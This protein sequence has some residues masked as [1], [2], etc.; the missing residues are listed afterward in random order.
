MQ[1]NGFALKLLILIVYHQECQTTQDRNFGYAIGPNTIYKSNKD[2]VITLETDVQPLAEVEVLH[3]KFRTKLK[4]NSI[5]ALGRTNEHSFK[6]ELMDGR[7]VFHFSDS[8]DLSISSYSLP[9]KQLDDGEWHRLIVQRT[10]SKFEVSIDGSKY[11]EI[12]FNKPLMQN[13][14][15][16]SRIILGFNNEL[17]RMIRFD[18]E[19]AEVITSVNN[20]PL[21]MKE[22]PITLNEMTDV[23]FPEQANEIDKVIIRVDMA[24]VAS[25]ALRPEERPLTLF[26]NEEKHVVSFGVSFRSATDGIIASM[27]GLR[28]KHFVGI[29]IVKQA[30]FLTVRSDQT[31]LQRQELGTV[32]PNT[33]HTLHL[34]NDRQ[35]DIAVISAWLTSNRQSPVSFKVSDPFLVDRISFGGRAND[36]PDLF[37]N[38]RPI[39]GC[40]SKPYL[41]LFTLDLKSLLPAGLTGCAVDGDITMLSDHQWRY[42]DHTEAITFH[43]GDRPLPFTYAENDGRN[44]SSLQLEFATV[45]PSGIIASLHDNK[46]NFIAL[47][48]QNGFLHMIIDDKYI[49]QQSFKVSE[50]LVNDGQYHRVKIVN[51]ERRQKDSRGKVVQTDEHQNYIELDSQ[52]VKF[53][54]PLADVLHVTTIYFAAADFWAKDHYSLASIGNFFGCMRRILFNDEQIIRY[55]HILDKDRINAGCQAIAPK[56]LPAIRYL[57]PDVSFSC[58]K[59]EDAVNLRL[60]SS[61]EFYSLTVPLATVIENGVI[62]SLSSALEK[63]TIVLYIQSGG[64]N[65]AYIDNDGKELHLTTG[66]LI[67]DGHRYRVFLKREPVPGRIVL[68]INDQTYNVDI[69]IGTKPL[70]FDKLTIGGPSRAMRFI[71]Q[72]QQSNIYEGCFESV[73]YNKGSIIPSGDI[74]DDRLQCSL[75]S[76]SICDKGNG[77]CRIDSHARRKIIDY[78]VGQSARFCPSKKCSLFCQSTPQ[79]VIRLK[80]PSQSST[81]QSI[82]LILRTNHQN[83]DIVKFSGNNGNSFAVN[84][85][86]GFAV[87]DMENNGKST[88]L[89]FPRYPV[90][91]ALHHNI[92]IVRNQSEMNLLMDDRQTAYNVK[93]LLRNRLT[94]DDYQICTGRYR[95]YIQDIQLLSGSNHINLIDKIVEQ[96]SFAQIGSAVVWEDRYPIRR[97]GLSSD[98]QC[99]S[100]VCELYNSQCRLKRGEEK[101]RVELPNSGHRVCVCVEP[102]RAESYPLCVFPGEDL[103]SQYECNHGTCNV[104]GNSPV[105]Q[106]FEGYTGEHCEYAVNPCSQSPCRNGGTCYPQSASSFV[107]YCPNGFTGRYCDHAATQD[108]CDGITCHNGGYCYQGQ[109]QCTSEYSGKYCEHG[110]DPCDFINCQNGGHCENSICICPSGFSGT[111]CEVYD[112]CHDISC[113]NGGVCENKV[114]RCP[115]PFTGHLCQHRDMCYGITCLHGGHCQDGQCLCS[116]GRGGAVCE[117]EV[118]AFDPCENKVCQNG[119]T[120]IDGKCTCP[121]GFFGEQCNER[122]PCFNVDCHDGGHCIDGLCVC[123]SG[124]YGDHCE[125]TD[126]CASV[127]CA[128]TQ[129]CVDGICECPAGYEG[130]SCDKLIV[131]I[132]EGWGPQGPLEGGLIEYGRVPRSRGKH[133]GAI[134]AIASGLALGALAGAFAARKCAEGACVPGPR[135]AAVTHIPVISEG[136]AVHPVATMIERTVPTVFAAGDAAMTSS[137]MSKGMRSGMEQE[138]LLLPSAADRAISD[139]ATAGAASGGQTERIETVHERMIERNYGGVSDQGSVFHAAPPVMHAVFGSPFVAGAPLGYKNDF[140]TPWSTAERQSER[141]IEA[142]M[143]DNSPYIQSV[144]GSAAMTGASFAYQPPP[145]NDFGYGPSAANQMQSQSIGYSDAE[146]W[147]AGTSYMSG[148]LGMN[149]LNV[150]QAAAQGVTGAG[151]VGEG[152]PGMDYELSNINT[153]TMTPNGK[154]A[155]VGQSQGPPQIWDAQNGNLI[156]S[157]YG[158]CNNCMQLE[159]AC[160]GTLLVGLSSDATDTQPCVVQIWDISTGRP[161]HLSHQIKCSAFTLSNNTNNIVMAGNQKYGRGISV[162]ILD[163]VS[164]ELTKELKSDTQTSLGRD[165][166]F[167]ALTPDEC[168]AVIGCF[169]RAQVMTNY[170][171]FDLTVAVDVVQPPSISLDCDPKR[172]VV[173]SN[174][175]CIS[176]LNNGQLFIWD[177][178]TCKPVHYFCDNSLDRVAHRGQINDI[179][180]SADRS[181]LITASKDNT[182]KVWDT[183]GKQLLTRLL[184]HHSDVMCA[185]LSGNQLLAVTGSSD[186]TICLWRLPSGQMAAQMNVGMAPSE[187]QLAAENRT[188]VSIAERDGERQ[189][190]M[191]RVVSSPPLKPMPPR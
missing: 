14:F 166:A 44:F 105:C 57:N 123:Y 3:L 27:T 55:D 111:L 107:C 181:L 157:L 98:H 62:A 58:R 156:N 22:V 124:H 172:C 144:G 74:S 64:L 162:G 69:P 179:H 158:N 21:K 141:L 50:R 109:C 12:S 190:L 56:P 147:E 174:K 154:Y 65:L 53:P 187:V 115:V 180:L 99:E 19:I 136:G 91:D 25:I 37:V 32:T 149:N 102:H 11:S 60:S 176:G 185:C 127:I 146:S 63:R 47:F 66:K 10:K 189:L 171:V 135:S 139:S 81:K 177:M 164:N 59:P 143:F 39:L 94:L 13:V 97:K 106:C 168:H 121:M 167:I 7:L 103:C 116:P 113:Q 15:T 125:I 38:S 95:G 82:S 133:L 30:L 182:A 191:L 41:N 54:K 33:E 31:D 152:S 188:V 23:S 78:D 34:W 67:N 36:D 52:K 43:H 20:I 79:S 114:C 128:S 130:P 85:Q 88:V 186:Q 9:S 28:S 83:A 89:E 119:G 16:G 184:G 84:L 18:G 80:M 76:G 108:P 145:I 5:I 120:C 159:L 24:P 138:E 169:N 122:D 1:L 71:P 148:A 170:V 165:P 110:R 86:N 112:P 8:S 90:A 2:H 153:L 104:D 151:V 175:E 35:G 150:S 126:L 4:E 163:L 51:S 42:I 40:V 140:Y 46:D 92:T 49:E 132:A 161:I 29:E 75:R 17:N 155:I 134:F 129:H 45:Q 70:F 118:P 178:S 96:P 68:A 87:L 131:P 183:V 6:I 73:E 137:A 142:Q 72:Q 61:E 100:Y 173:L 93:G 26:Y 117:N 101:I 77:L 48:L 160:S